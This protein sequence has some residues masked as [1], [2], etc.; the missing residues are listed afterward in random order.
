LTFGTEFN[1]S[2]SE[3]NLPKSLVSLIL[4]VKFN[5]PIDKLPENL[6]SLT[7]GMNFYQSVNIFPPKL[8]YLSFFSCSPIKDNIPPSVEIVEINLNICK[9]GTV[10]NLPSTIKIIKVGN[11]HV[12][13]CITRIPFGCKIVK[14]D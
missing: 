7:F 3:G 14:I 8:S 12:K 11:D 4:G 13:D 9:Y 1:Q 10:D 2:I 5:Q 6:L